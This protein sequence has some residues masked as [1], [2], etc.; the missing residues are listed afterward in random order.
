MQSRSENAAPPPLWQNNR[1]ILFVVNTSSAVVQ[2]SNYC[3]SVSLS[4][5]DVRMSEHWIPR[6]KTA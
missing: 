4:Q 1:G 2:R 3:W 6:E 5:V